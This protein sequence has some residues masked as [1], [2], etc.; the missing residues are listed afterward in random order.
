MVLGLDISTWQTL[1]SIS[2]VVTM[3]FAAW[4]IYL[5]AKSTRAQTASIDFATATG[6]TQELEK[7]TD[8]L[9]TWP[10]EH[11]RSA[12]RSLLNHTEILAGFYHHRK[13]QRL[14]H[15]VVVKYLI[16]V[17]AYI[18]EI[19]D[20]NR[21]LSPNLESHRPYNSIIEFE[22]QHKVQID[23]RRKRLKAEYAAAQKSEQVAAS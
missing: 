15:Y 17:I 23:E 8:R 6:L 7:Y 11:Q 14:T 16:E 13:F 18:R 5:N 2:T 22:I 9:R 20:G 4:A 10:E 1:G 21:M 12:L 3:L 19:D